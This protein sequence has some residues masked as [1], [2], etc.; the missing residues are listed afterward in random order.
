MNLEGSKCW[1]VYL[2]ARRWH[3]GILHNLH[4]PSIRKG[5]QTKR[6]I[7]ERGIRREADFFC[8]KFE[9]GI[10]EIGIIRKGSQHAIK[11]LLK[12]LQGK[13]SY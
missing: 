9:S 4:F 11:S 12:K 10:K 5:A 8:F 1:R 13:V 6:D 7:K 3:K 2:D